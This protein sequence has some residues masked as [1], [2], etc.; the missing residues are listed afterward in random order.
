MTACS[1]TGTTAPGATAASGAMAAPAADAAIRKNLQERLPQLPPIEEIRA[2]AMPGLYEVRV[3]PAGIFYTDAQGDFLI[4]GAMMDTKARRNLTEERIN[5]LNAIDFSTLPLKDAIVFKSGNGRR[6]LAVFEDPNC[7]Y[8]HRL[9]TELAKVKNLT[10]YM[11]LYP[12]LGPDSTAKSQ[13]IWCAANRTKAWQDWMLRQKTPAA[14]QCDTAAV[15]R[16]LEFGRGHRITGT[17][18]I[19]F[20]DGRRVSGAMDAAALENMLEQKP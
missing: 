1:K 7:S 18:T 17:P 16:I 14:A 6:K 15:Q 2:T 12:I 8:C 5:A 4:Q 11:F 20:E 9:E 13:N 10:V 3:G 19:V